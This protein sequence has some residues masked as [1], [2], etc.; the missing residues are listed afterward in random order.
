MLFKRHTELYEQLKTQQIQ[1]ERY[2]MCR[3][4]ASKGWCI[5]KNIFVILRFCFLFQYLQR[6]CIVQWGRFFRSLSDRLFMRQ[7]LEDAGRLKLIE[8]LPNGLDT[9][10]DT[11]WRYKRSG[12]CDC[13]RYRGW[14]IERSE[15]HAHSC[16]AQRVRGASR[17]FWFCSG[18]WRLIA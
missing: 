12:C 10:I 11:W 16:H 15:S 2:E 7:A 18:D 8:S 1:V 5:W 3:F 6:F 17:S 4:F 9:V 14:A 13:L